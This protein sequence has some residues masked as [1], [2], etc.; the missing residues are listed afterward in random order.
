MI[1]WT[2]VVLALGSGATWAM[3]HF[4][5][6]VETKPPAVLPPLVRSQ[7]VRAKDLRIDVETEGTVAPRTEIF[8]A[9]EVAGK[10]TMVPDSLAAGG[11]FGADDVLVKLDDR[12]FKVAIAQAEARVAQA[13]V[14]LSRE[15]AEAEIAR[16]EWKQLG[17]G[18]ASPLTLREP[19]VQE[20][21][22][23]VAAAQAALEKAE[24]D[25]ERTVIRAPFAGRV[26]TKHVDVGQFVGRGATL[27]RIYAVDYAEVRLPLHDGKL[28]F[29]DL[30]LQY[31]GEKQ[32]TNTCHVTLRARFGGREHQWNGTIVRTE[33]EIDSKSR[34]VHAIARVDNP[35]S[36][37]ANPD[38]PPL[39]VGMFVSAT[40]HGKLFS[41]VIELPRD[42][43]RGG[44][45]VLV[46]DSESRLHFRTVA[47]LRAGYETAILRSGLHD[48][49][50][51]CLSPL[52][53]VVDGMQVRLLSDQP[54]T[55]AGRNNGR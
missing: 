44:N 2:V 10:V 17:R 33:G 45:R 53:T 4:R 5:N 9:A 35:Y 24:L 42:A 55:G 29:L 34:M 11:F 47:I 32:A 14:L 50:R 28:Q 19:Q 8:L 21:K 1:F 26:R 31:R 27:A 54:P 23:A 52:A 43:L 13:K 36:K 38:R 37:G 49:E 51:I 16:R 20:A 22:A 3:I 12:D 39:A 30:P 46:I 48:G 6:V 41:N 25:L 18:E 7:V 40:I 15:Q